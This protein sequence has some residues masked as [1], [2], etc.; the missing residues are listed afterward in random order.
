M[1]KKVKQSPMAFMR[2]KKRRSV[3]LQD[4]V[5]PCACCGYRLSH[6]HHLFPIAEW[7]GNNQ[8]IPLCANCH[9]LYHIVFDVIRQYESGVKYLKGRSATFFRYLTQVRP[10]PDEQMERLISTVQYV[11][12]EQKT[13]WQEEE[14]TSRELDKTMLDILPSLF[15]SVGDD[16]NDDD[17]PYS[18]GTYPR[19][20]KN[21]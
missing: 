15:G 3:T 9:E 20:Y 21:D 1:S 16:F 8:T 19:D 17:F 14:Q 6:R 13:A 18:D 7:G 10:S 12:G 4:R 11:L 5:T 2:P